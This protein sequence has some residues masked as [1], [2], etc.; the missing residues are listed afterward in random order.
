MSGQE[1]DRNVGKAGRLAPGMLHPGM[2][3][4][5]WH[6]LACLALSS[7]VPHFF[8]FLSFP[9]PLGLGH[10]PQLLPISWKPEVSR[11]AGVRAPMPPCCWLN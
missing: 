4:L 5:G 7:S 1:H 2:L 10:S 6:P 3:Q 9:V 11:H 8:N